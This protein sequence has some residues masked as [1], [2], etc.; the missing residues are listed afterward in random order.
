V[1]DVSLSGSEYGQFDRNNGSIGIDFTKY[2]RNKASLNARGINL[3]SI[4]GHE[5][6]HLINYRLGYSGL[7]L[8]EGEIS[9][10]SI[11]WSAT[12]LS[13]SLRNYLVGRLSKSSAYCPVGGKDMDQKRAK[14]EPGAES[15]IN[16]CTKK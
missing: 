3:G 14:C 8:M 11:E 4:G 15:A 13:Q 5:V 6:G 2:D 12:N 10:M 16:S 9:S 1:S 7:G